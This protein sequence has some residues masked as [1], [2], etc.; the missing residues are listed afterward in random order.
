M[1]CCPRPNCCYVTNWG[2]DPPR[3]GESQAVSSGSPI[4]VDARGIANQGTVSVLEPREGKWQQVKT[5]RVGL[6]PSG[7]IVSS[8][9]QFVFVA[10]ANSDTVSVIRTDTGGNDF[11][12]SRRPAS[13]R[14]WLQRLGPESVGGDAL[15]RQWH[16]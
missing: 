4:R 6:H 5:I 9:G 10:N 8:T 1:V 14:Q 11:L 7:M 16:Q 15:C 3:E 13:F 2:G 12:P